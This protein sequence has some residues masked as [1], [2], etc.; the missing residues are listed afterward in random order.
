MYKKRLLVSFF[1]I[2][3]VGKISANEV[4][5]TLEIHGVN[6]NGGTVIGGIYSNNSYNTRNPPEFDFQRDPVNNIIYFTLQIPQ[7]EWVIQVF[8]DTND[9]GRLDFGLFGIPREPIGISN[10]NGRGSPGNFNRHKVSIYNGSRIAVQLS[11][12]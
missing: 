7:G 6:V 1:V 11:P 10:W 3:L 9:N 4:S 8:Q 5:F 12:R 2:L